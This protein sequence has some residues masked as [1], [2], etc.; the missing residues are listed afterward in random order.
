MNEFSAVNCN[1][2]K[3]STEE[4]ASNLPWKE[5][6]NND[7]DDDDSDDND[8]SLWKPLGTNTNSVA[9][10]C[11]SALSKAS[12]LKKRKQKKKLFV[13][14]KMWKPSKVSKK[15]T[16]KTSARVCQDRLVFFHFDVVEIVFYWHSTGCKEFTIFGHFLEICFSTVSRWLFF[17][18][19]PECLTGASFTAIRVE[20][21][22][23]EGKRG[24][25]FGQFQQRDDVLVI[26]NAFVPRLRCGFVKMVLMNQLP[27]DVGSLCEASKGQLIKDMYG[28]FQN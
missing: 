26:I 16:P 3:W 7:H 23:R 24:D 17:C 14:P 2:T 19:G 13:D 8:C 12:F 10:F 6:H 11:H 25:F 27:V 20:P 21:K 22:I 28:L 15:D 9:P 1:Q 5:Y 4:K 18:A